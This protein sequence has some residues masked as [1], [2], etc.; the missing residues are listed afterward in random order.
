[1][2]VLVSRF[3]NIQKVSLNA[4]FLRDASEFAPSD[5]P[6][7]P[8]HLEHLRM[9]LGF[10][11]STPTQLLFAAVTHWFHAG[12]VGP[13]AIRALEL[14][15]LDAQS[16]PSVG[17]LLRSM[18]PNLRDLDLRLMYHVN[19]GVFSLYTHKA[20]PLIVILMS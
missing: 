2:F 10:Y 11:R 12:E 14:G 15:F 19:A 18:G 5:F 20:K 3:S 1:M 7:M 6:H 4:V 8:R 9:R 16:I 13:P 17:N